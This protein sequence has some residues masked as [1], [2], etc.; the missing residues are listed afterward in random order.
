MTPAHLRLNQQRT[1]S[2]ASLATKRQQNDRTTT[3]V[4]SDRNEAQLRSRTNRLRCTHPLEPTEPRTR[5]TTTRLDRNIQHDG[6]V[7]QSD[8]GA[9]ADAAASIV[10]ATATSTTVRVQS[11]RYRLFVYPS[12]ERKHQTTYVRVRL[13][14]INC[15][16]C[17][18][19]SPLPNR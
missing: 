15:C 16:C 9:Q 12:T 7:D 14:L 10:F 8:Y 17:S 18:F 1:P 2:H 3:A 11:T 6:R 13:Y 4:R 19:I 5:L